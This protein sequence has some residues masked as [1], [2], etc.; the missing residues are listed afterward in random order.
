MKSTP[1]R[2]SPVMLLKF[3]LQIACICLILAVLAMLLLNFQA[4]EQLFLQF[5][6]WVR[7]NPYIAVFACIVVYT[8]SICFL[9]P[10]AATHVIIGFTYSQ[11]FQSQWRGLLFATAVVQ[12]SCMIA[13]FTA[14]LLSRYLFRDFILQQIKQYPWLDKNFAIIND[15]LREQGLVIVA[16][17][18]LTFVPF[19][20]LSHVMGVTDISKWDYFLGNL[21]YLVNAMMQVFIGCSL[22]ALNS[23]NLTN[24]SDLHNTE[25]SHLQQSVF[26][27]EI[28]VSV[29]ITMTMAYFAKKIVSERLQA[30]EAD[31]A[32]TKVKGR[33]MLAVDEEEL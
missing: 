1:V 8:V 5:I 16:L 10:I 14:F 2:K 24:L 26:L 4:A 11:V 15:L 31:Q 3:G 22:Y 25:S 30:L 29:V 9:I 27:F 21:S 33:P 28:G 17:T 7:N 12:V 19:G 20:I 18:R 23:G 13:A 32:Q 6:H